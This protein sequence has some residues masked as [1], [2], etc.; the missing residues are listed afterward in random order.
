MKK[1]GTVKPGLILLILLLFGGLVLLLAVGIGSVPIAPADTVKVLLNQFWGISPFGNPDETTVSILWKIRIPRTLLAFIAG[2]G[3]SV[4]GVL[5]QSVLKNPLASSFTLGVSSGAAFGAGIALVFGLSVFGFLTL[6]VFGLISGLLTVFLALGVA[7]GLDSNLQN[8]SVILT[9]MAFSLFANAM[10]T[11]LM[12]YAQEQLQ[13]L[14]FWQ[15]GSFSMKLPE[16]VLILLPVVLILLLVSMGFAGQM[17]IMTL[18]DEQ[19]MTTG[20]EMKRNK[21]ILLSIGAVMTGA[22]VSLVGVIGFLD[23][24]TPH[25]AR[26]LVGA[27]HKYVIPA[28]ALLG[29]AFMVLCD[30]IAR[31]V[32]APRELPVGAVTAV[33]GAPFFLYLFF[34]GKRQSI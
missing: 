15:M 11:I 2:S 32:A 6:P 1:N 8:H 20:I 5:M 4:S 31:T 22:V 24:F 10:I 16:H 25:M 33:I 29:G 14:I 9:G 34:S 12:V 18:G 23:L 19:A 17:D 30:L 28:S 26:K 21:W 3:L 13:R 7:S 27:R